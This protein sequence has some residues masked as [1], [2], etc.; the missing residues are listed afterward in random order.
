[1]V[2]KANVKRFTDDILPLA[3]SKCQDRR[4]ATFNLKEGFVMLLDMSAGNDKMINFR[5]SARHAVEFK[6]ACNAKGKGM[7]TVL[8]EFILR[9][10][11][12]VRDSDPGGF[13]AEL[14]MIDDP[15][16]VVV[17]ANNMD[18]NAKRTDRNRRKA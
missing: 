18:D 14:S 11:S 16:V 5:V 12:S 8:K 15:G 1:M 6:A 7:T 2:C 9:Y 4:I 10:I 17:D 13:A 3:Y